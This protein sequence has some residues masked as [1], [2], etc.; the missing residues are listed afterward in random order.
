M[1]RLVVVAVVCCFITVQGQTYVQPEQIHLSYG[2]DPSRMFVTWVTFDNTT[3]SFVD[4]GIKQLTNR[5]SGS[6]TKFVDG[7]SAK[8]TLYIHRVLLTN[9]TAAQ[10]YIYRVGSDYGW[11]VIYYF[12]ALP[13]VATW[14]PRFAVYGDMG[15]VNAQSLGR[16]QTESQMGHFD[17]ILHVGDMAYNL[18][19]NDANYGDQFLRQ[20]E[21]I[22]AYVPYMTVVGN[23]EAAYNF[24]NYV[25]RFTM[26]NG[27]ANLFYSFDIG[28]I[29]FIA[30]STEFYFFVEYG[31]AQIATQ[32]QWLIQDLQ[33][34]NANRG[35]VPWIITMGHRPMYC[36]NADQDDCTKYESIIRGGLPYIHA[37]G[38]EDVFYKYGVDLELWA[39]EH[40]YERMWP[41]YNR[42]VYNGSSNPY[43][44]PCAPVHIVAGAAGCQEKTDPF[45]SDPGP[46]SAYRSSDY[47]YG[48]MKVIN[49]T[50]LYYEEVSDDKNG[51]VIDS[52]TLVRNKHAPYNPAECKHGSGHTVSMDWQAPPPQP[53]K[54]MKIHRSSIGM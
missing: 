52:F 25:N 48:R 15:N 51:T 36:S 46:W 42:T 24:S 19:T 44:D 32:Y 6:M 49:A 27:V 30:F 8:R 26:P 31:W 47:G 37:Y 20:I 12:T 10:T 16:L 38:L 4:Y 11:S 5:T 9:L 33:K 21:P 13:T 29:H 28:P 45:I 43:V 35:K 39:H 1:T 54:N 14:T 17:M 34:A 23:H 18:D 3:Q 53:R 7:G 2:G 50:H 41:V 40:S 22:A